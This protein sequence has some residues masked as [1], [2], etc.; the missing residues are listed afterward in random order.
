MST[1]ETHSP[2]EKLWSGRPSHWNYFGQYVAGII[3]ASAIAAAIFFSRE[4]LAQALP[5]SMPWAYG[6]SLLPVLLVI[7]SA[8]IQRM[9]RH[10]C[11]TSRRVVIELG[12][13]VK[14]SNEIR[15]Q[16]IRSINVT[17]RGLGGLFGIGTVEFSSAATDDAEVIFEKIAR[18]DSVRDLVRKLQS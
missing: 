9:K 1:D 4:N 12:L 14:D 2:E 8:A 3:A 6:L 7:A 18:A 13:I 17:K 16:D 15:I 10:Y 11:V 5:G